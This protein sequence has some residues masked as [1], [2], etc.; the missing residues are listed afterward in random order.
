MTN[1]QTKKLGN[2]T[3]K[4]GSGVTPRGG[5]DVFV[6]DGVFFIRSQNIKNNK[7]DMSDRKYIPKIIDENM[8]SSRVQMNDI[9]YNITGASIGRSAVYESTLEANVNQ[10]VCIV[11]I[12]EDNPKFVQYA[13]SSEVGAR[14][15]WGFQAGGNREGLNFQQLA[16]FK[17]QIPEKPEQERIVRVLE[18]WDEYIEKLERKIALKEQLKKGLMQQLL[19]GKR[20]L[21]GS[22]SPWITHDFSGVFNVMSKHPGYKSSEYLKEGS[23]PIY[24]QSYDKH[25]SGYTDEQG[26]LVNS[27]QP[28]TLFGDHSRVVKYIDSENF[29]VGNDGIKLLKAQNNVDDY[30]ACLL[31]KS[32][33]VPNTGYNRH[34]KY[35]T[36]ATFDMPEC[37]EQKQISI[38][39]KMADNEVSILSSKLKEVKLQ[40]RYILK[41]LITGTIRTPEN[42]KHFEVQS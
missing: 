42:L 10:H 29:A 37:D 23:Y 24:D 5:S 41:N 11:R 6:D 25:V 36:D 28:L 13:L 35:I 8:R 15:L 3:Q 40:K 16:S 18:V 17:I 30:Y 12:K 39:I 38:V 22:R 34:F 20:R 1:W 7:V 31:L 32:Y 27:E 2:L 33:K 4:I 19:T 26:R 9:L 14:N 21:P